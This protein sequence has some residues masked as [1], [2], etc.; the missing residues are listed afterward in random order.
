M[1]I[2]SCTCILLQ[3]GVPNR[4]KLCGMSRV[5]G[6]PLESNLSHFI[7]SISSSFGAVCFCL[8]N[9]D[10]RCVSYFNRP[11]CAEPTCISCL[12]PAAVK[13]QPDSQKLQAAFDT[14]FFFSFVL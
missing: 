10:W 13:A 7:Q 11:T 2:I 5:C 8:F 4:N 9:P 3:T 6:F 12:V 1:W 14:A